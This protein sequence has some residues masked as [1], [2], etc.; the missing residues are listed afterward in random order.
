MGL[1][2]WLNPI[3]KVI[4]VVGAYVNKRQDVD[5]EKY[6]VNGSISVKAMETDRDI[7]HWDVSY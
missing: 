2:S 6:R 4:D 5:L 3:S 7:I 1:L